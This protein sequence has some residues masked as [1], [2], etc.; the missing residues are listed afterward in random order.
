[1]SFDFGSEALA[2]LSCYYKAIKIKRV[3]QLQGANEEAYLKYVTSEQRNKCVAILI[4]VFSAAS[5][6]TRRCGRLHALIAHTAL[7]VDLFY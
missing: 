4:L 1:M 7:S 6:Y 5:A 3:M 2:L